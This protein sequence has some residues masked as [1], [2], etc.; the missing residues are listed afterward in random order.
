MFNEPGG[1]SIAGGKMYV[2]DT[3]N[4]RIQI[5][6]MKTKEIATLKLQGVDPVRRMEA[7]SKEKKAT[8]KSR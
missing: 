8:E 6:D 3:N 2:A 7:A 1:L 5:V 4:Q